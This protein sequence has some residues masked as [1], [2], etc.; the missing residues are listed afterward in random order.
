M[1]T[2]YFIDRSD[3]LD[4]ARN[5]LDKECEEITEDTKAKTQHSA[6]SNLNMSL[7]IWLFGNMPNQMLSKLLS[8]WLLGNF[9]GKSNVEQLLINST[10]WKSLWPAHQKADPC[11]RA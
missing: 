2:T 3:N 11:S 6:K 8:I 9:C 10:T 5:V 1:N 4:K 7:S